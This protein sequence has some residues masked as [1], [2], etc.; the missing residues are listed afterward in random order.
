MILNSEKIR[1]AVFIL[2]SVILLIYWIIIYIPDTHL[3]GN[4]QDI[5]ALTGNWTINA[6]D[7]VRSNVSLSDANIGISIKDREYT[8]SRLLPKDEIPGACLRIHTVHS[9]VR[10]S[11]SGRQIYSFE[12][13]GSDHVYPMCY[14]YVPLNEG[15]AGQN[16][17]IT[18]IPMQANA[19]SGFSTIYLGSR[20]D[21]QLMYMS[22]IRMSLYLGVFLCIMGIITL[23]LAPFLTA[24]RPGD[25]RLFFCSFVSLDLGI[26]I[27]SINNIFN[28]ISDNIIM[29][30]YMEYCS[31]YLIPATIS[32]YLVSIT[33]KRAIRF[34]YIILSVLNVAFFIYTISA[35]ILRIQLFSTHTD[36]VHVLCMIEGPIIICAAVY[37]LIKERKQLRRDPDTVSTFLLLAGLVVFMLCSLIEIVIFNIKK[38][39]LCSGDSNIQHIVITY[40]ALFF[41]L[42]LFISYFVYYVY[43]IESENRQKLLRGLAYYDPLTKLSNRAK[44]Q[45]EMMALSEGDAPY[46]IISID[47]DYL[48]TINDTYGHFEGDRYL[49]SFASRLQFSFRSDDLIG[50]TGGDEF[51][52]ILH[53]DSVEAATSR[54]KSIQLYAAGRRNDKTGGKYSF[55][56]GI[57][58]STEI[59]TGRAEDVF[60]MADNRMYEMKRL[61]HAQN[62]RIPVFGRT[63]ELFVKGGGRS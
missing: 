33:R 20:N 21:L 14:L 6:P 59:S 32:A 9:A 11:L 3:Y 26:Y 48:K 17:S 53:D 19:F 27:M 4:S 61:R 2:I 7:G 44:C 18:F 49:K 23:A 12:G 54:I 52:V 29:N 15:Y 10:V 45:E 62:S 1:S 22:D 55:S 58:S 13:P 28:L 57:C 30:T 51:M 36:S 34:L 63:T 47:L 25:F 24:K 41:V 43:G 42:T 38:Y 60:R 40:G 50:R 56:Y 39:F 5:Y 16:L 46:I 31:L 37:H 8:I 35:H